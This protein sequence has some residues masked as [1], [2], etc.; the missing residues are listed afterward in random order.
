MGSTSLF[1]HVAT[2]D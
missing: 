1:D 2:E